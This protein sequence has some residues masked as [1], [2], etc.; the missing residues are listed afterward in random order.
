MR[1]I[2]TGYLDDLDNIGGIFDPSK[3][4]ELEIGEIAC[5]NALLSQ[6]ANIISLRISNPQAQDKYN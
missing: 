1:H 4:I 6:F 3:I 5:S 2:K